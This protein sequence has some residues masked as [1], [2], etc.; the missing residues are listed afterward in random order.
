MRCLKVSLC[1]AV[2]FGASMAR[3]ADDDAKAILEKAI[4]AHGGEDNLTKYK[5]GM[6]KVKG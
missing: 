1:A 4:K 3:A 2:V 6:M 5:A